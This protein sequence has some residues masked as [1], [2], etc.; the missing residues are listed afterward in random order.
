MKFKIKLSIMKDYIKRLSTSIQSISSRNE[1][2]GVLIEVWENYINFEGRNDWMDIKIEEQ[3]LENIKIF[4][5]GKALI[6]AQLLNEVIQKMDGEWI[7]F[8]MLDSTIIIVE[9]EN[10]NY[11]INLLVNENYEKASLVTDVNE[12]IAIKPSVFKKIVSKT[13]F[14]G[15]EFHP[16][17]I[18][19]G[20]NIKVEDGKISTIVCDGIR[21]AIF[22]MK[23][24]IS[25]K[26][27]KIIPLKVIKELLKI[28]P[29]NNILEYNFLFNYNTGIVVAGNMTCQFRYI[30]GTF[31]SFKNHIDS[32]QYNK[33]LLITKDNLVKYIEKVTVLFHSLEGTRIGLN[34]S[35]EKFILESRNQ[36]IG[37]AKINI[38]NFKYDGD[39]IDISLSPKFLIDVLKVADSNDILLLFKNEKSGVLFKS[40]G[41]ELYCLISPMI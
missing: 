13:L 18:F 12:K 16:K 19:Q 10:S 37:S 7:S 25:T 21:V 22:S 3:S 26:I 6:K 39:E 27:N 17:F 14:A 40:N 30:E 32:T 33:E 23:A 11:K 4:E 15:N 29:N 28:L 31:P 36:E 38:T 20:M 8:T 24:S 5:P 2:T 34:I 9:N 35:K 41:D 1:F